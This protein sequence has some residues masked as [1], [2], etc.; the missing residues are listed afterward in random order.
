MRRRSVVMT[1]LRL[2]AIAAGFLVTVC[3]YILKAC[4]TKYFVNTLRTSRFCK[5]VKDYND[6]SL[7]S[8]TKINSHMCLWCREEGRYSLSHPGCHQC[9]TSSPVQRKQSSINAHNKFP[10]IKCKYEHTFG[11]YGRVSN[12]PI[13]WENSI[14]VS[15]AADPSDPIDAS[16]PIEFR[17]Q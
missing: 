14:A 10:K 9:A 2:L 11:K 3:S 1:D 17:I 4:T 7:N 16:D 5:T 15:N 13:L 6:F 12:S 8:L